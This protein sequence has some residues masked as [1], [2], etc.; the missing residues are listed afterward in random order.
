MDVRANFFTHTP[1][2]AQDLELVEI[3]KAFSELTIFGKFQGQMSCVQQAPLNLVIGTSPTTLGIDQIVEVL[4]LGRMSSDVYLNLLFELIH[5]SRYS[6]RGLCGGE[7]LM[8]CL[9]TSRPMCISCS[10]VWC[11]LLLRKKV[12]LAPV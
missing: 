6:R 12:P 7:F 3:L 10:K 5:M 4:Q 11:S 8:V 9:R 2:Q 1:T